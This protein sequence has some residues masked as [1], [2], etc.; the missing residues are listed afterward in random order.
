MSLQFRPV[1]KPPMRRF[2]KGEPP[3]SGSPLNEGDRQASGAVHRPELTSAGLRT[4]GVRDQTKQAVRGCRR[5]LL[6]V[7]FGS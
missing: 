6:A 7:T 3:M 1:S 4:M 5:L 2:A